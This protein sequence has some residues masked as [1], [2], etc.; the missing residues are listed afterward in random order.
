M[1]GMIS[2]GKMEA[3]ALISPPEKLQSKF[4]LIFLKYLYGREKYYISL[5]DLNDSFSAISKKEFSGQ[6]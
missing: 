3:I 4:E 1:K 5:S 2:K 6:L